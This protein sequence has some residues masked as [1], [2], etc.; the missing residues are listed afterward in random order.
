MEGNYLPGVLPAEDEKSISLYNNY[1]KERSLYNYQIWDPS[2]LH[3][4]YY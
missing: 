2:P 4:K 3:L 1:Q